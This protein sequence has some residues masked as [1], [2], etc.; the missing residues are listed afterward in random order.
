MGQKWG[1]N[2]LIKIAR[3]FFIL[4]FLFCVAKNI[5]KMIKDL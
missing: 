5:K 2:N 1:K 3:F 4:G